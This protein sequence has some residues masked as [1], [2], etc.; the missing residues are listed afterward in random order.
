MSC[1]WQ[2]VRAKL[3]ELS[4]I[5]YLPFYNSFVF[6]FKKVFQSFPIYKF[7]IEKAYT[8]F[9]RMNLFRPSET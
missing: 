1:G 7:Q 4:L 8:F 5:D 3:S 6:D 2:T 9:K